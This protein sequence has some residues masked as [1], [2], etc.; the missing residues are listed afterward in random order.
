MEATIR[1]A[2]LHFVSS[3]ASAISGGSSEGAEEEGVEDDIAVAD[4]LSMSTKQANKHL[5]MTSIAA[6]RRCK[7]GFNVPVLIYVVV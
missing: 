3:R 6:A 7:I 1:D 4:S 2:E 5:N